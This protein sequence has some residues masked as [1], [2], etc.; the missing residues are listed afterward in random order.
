MQVERK[1]I[2][3]RL[4]FMNRLLLSITLLLSFPAL[5]QEELDPYDK[6]GPPGAMVYTNLKDALKKC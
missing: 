4:Q 2:I 1:I 6:Y 5:A 3:A